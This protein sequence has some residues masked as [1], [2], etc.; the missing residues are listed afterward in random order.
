MKTWVKIASAVT[1]FILI[2][3]FVILLMTN[4]SLQNPQ[5]EKEYA[6]R[7]E[8]KKTDFSSFEG[9]RVEIPFH[10]KNLGTAKWSSKGPDPC[11]L[12]YHLL[13]ETE[14]TIQYDNRRFPLPEDTPPQR[15][16]DMDVAV[17]SP[18]DSGKYILEFDIVREGISWFKDYGS[19]TAKVSLLVEKRPWPED[20]YDLSLDYGKYT[21]FRT[22]LDTLNRIQKLIRLTLQHN[23]V[24]FTGKTGTVSGFSAGKDYPQIWLRDA[25]TIIPASRYHYGLDFLSSWIEE[26]LSF[27]KKNGSLEDWI[28]SAG[29]S[30]K[31]TTETDQESSAV[32]AAYQIFELKGPEWLEKTIQGQAVIQRLER[33]LLYV[34]DTRYDKEL[35][36]LT[37]AHTADWGDVDMVDSDTRAI[38]TDSNTHW[39]A[40]IYDQSMFYEACLQLARMFDALDLEEKRLFWEGKA[41]LIKANTNKWLWQEDK[42]FYRVHRHLGSLAH[43]F[44]EQDMFASGGNTQAILS[45]LADTDQAA[46]IIQEALN[47]QESFNISTLSASLLPPYPKNTFKHPMVDDPYEYQ[48]GGQ[49]D[50]FGG[51]LVYVMFEKGFSRLARAK[52]EEILEKNWANRGFFEWDTQEG[53]GQG[54]G[55]FCGSA[56]SLSKAV[57]EGLLGIKVG[58]QTVG[59]EPKLGKESAFV[60]VYLPAAD[61]FIAYR[62]EFDEAEDSLRMEYSSSFTSQ[63]R[64]KILNPWSSDVM[65]TLDGKEVD[66]S[67]ERRNKDEFI[68]VETDFRNHV[69]EVTK[70]E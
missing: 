37:G 31:N 19:Q 14:S 40:D 30:D 67:L 24:S 6:S 28:D 63:G 62:Y 27:Q 58:Q 47:R 35:G 9:E 41:E 2:P 65:V 42:G 20:D 23:E 68:V 4:D 70:R 29:R 45:G 43:D 12:S 46:R 56:G 64:L 26:H 33:A 25:N 10:I 39:T 44:D 50:W 61:K 57:Y 22:S 54:G 59:L 49:W 52:L 60:H 7:I 8:L 55:Y 34:L 13:D 16:F 5:G 15:S 18:L 11:F 17:I 53:V 38:Y 32:Q 21:K 48:N 51:K 69:V 1:L 66:F 3:A 36:L